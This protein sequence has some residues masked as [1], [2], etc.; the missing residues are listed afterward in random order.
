[1]FFFITAVSSVIFSVDFGSDNIKLGIARY[2]RIETALNQQSKRYT[3]SYF[4]LYNMSNKQKTNFPTHWEKN[5]TRQLEWLFSY[6]AQNHYKRFPQNVIKGMPRLLENHLGMT[7]R[8]IM[9]L[10]LKQLISTSADGRFPFEQSTVVLAVEP[11]MTRRERQAIREAIS[12]GGSTL[13]GIIDSP[14]A[15]SITYGLERQSFYYNSSRTVA[16]LDLGQSHTWVSIFNFTSNGTNLHNVQLSMSSNMTLGGYLVDDKLANLFI[17]EF[18]RQYNIKDKLPKKVEIKFYEEARRV[19]ERLTLSLTTTANIEDVYEDYSFSMEVTRETLN[20]LLTDVGESLCRLLDESLLM[21]NISKSQ[22]DSIELLGGTTRVPF[23]NETIINWSGMEKLNRTMNSDEAIAIGACYA[24]AAT[25]SA[26]IIQKVNS[27]LFSNVDVFFRDNDRSKEYKV[28]G[29]QDLNEHVFFNFSVSEMPLNIT[30]YV[31]DDGDFL[32]YEI[33]KPNITEILEKLNR[34]NVT[35]ENVTVEN[36]TVENVT[37][38]E[39]LTEEN[40]TVV[41]E[42][43]F[44]QIGA[45]ALWDAR[46][47]G[48]QLDAN[49]KTANWMLTRDE[50]SNS[51]SFLRK[52]GHVIKKRIDLLRLL[53]DHESLIFKIRDRLESDS[54]F[55]E[56]TTEEERENISREVDIHVSWKEN[57]TETKTRKIVLDKVR[58]LESLTDDADDRIFERKNRP[59]AIINLNNTLN[60][61]KYSL[62]DLPVSKPWLSGENI[63][64]LQE[65]Y[66][67]TLEWFEEKLKLISSENVTS[68]PVVHTSE[69]NRRRYSLEDK[70][71]KIKDI[72]KPK[73]V[74]NSTNTT[75]TNE[76]FIDSEFWNASFLNTSLFYDNVT[77]PDMN[78]TNVNETEINQ[79][80]PTNETVTNTTEE[81]N[82]TITT[83]QTNTTT[84][85]Q[86]NSEQTKQIQDEL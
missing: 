2:G 41:Y 67:S 72:P 47:N 83:E 34:Q 54:E 62:E 6:D 68:N 57:E 48:I 64:S 13:A 3:P 35:S 4:A 49:V 22:L 75:A 38:N 85:S 26:F 84:S 40:L 7:G 45:P 79:T 36:V 59:Q 78:A 70:L 18:K 39:T 42:F 23:F 11:W 20:S 77:S 58:Q 53:N 16:F 21:A 76:T 14:Q 24:G 81:V 1:M 33:V 82:Q 15:A 73:P 12:I 71:Q 63:S 27:K 46:I 31:A 5:D 25:S 9:A 50:I 29:K 52:M 44:D 17:S 55:I 80:V 8:E 32:T 37:S 28:Y 51:S 30:V 66:N 69:I 10:I 60:E 65:I 19:K 56:V 74:S 61:T 43:G 86:D